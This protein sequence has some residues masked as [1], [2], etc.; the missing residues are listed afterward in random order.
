MN[1]EWLLNKIQE[2]QNRTLDTADALQLKTGIERDRYAIASN[3]IRLA[4]YLVHGGEERKT[5]N[6]WEQFKCDMEAFLA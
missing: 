5:K 6:Y 2:T 4:W 3:A 1:K